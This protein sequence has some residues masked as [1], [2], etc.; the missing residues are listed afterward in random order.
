MLNRVTAPN[1]ER[2]EEAFDRQEKQWSRTSEKVESDDIRK[3]IGNKRGQS[4]P[5]CLIGGYQNKIQQYV[6]H[7]ADDS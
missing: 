4:G 6:A 1:I 3:E 7:S 5:H 2:I